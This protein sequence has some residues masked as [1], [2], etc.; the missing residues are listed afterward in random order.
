MRL[1]EN[2][3]VLAQIKVF[4]QKLPLGT[5]LTLYDLMRYFPNQTESSLS[6]SLSTLRN[7]GYLTTEEEKVWS[8][9]KTKKQ[10]Q[11]WF[12]IVVIAS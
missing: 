8:V 7:L 12:A 6:A 10:F 3:S 9:Y 1:P 5:A 2:P 11:T 4:M